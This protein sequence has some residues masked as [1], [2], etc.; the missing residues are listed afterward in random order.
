MSTLGL[1]RS[2]NGNDWIAVNLTVGDQVL[3]SPT[4]NFATWNK[5]DTASDLVTLS[6]GNL[7]AV[8][9]STNWAQT[10]ANIKPT[11]G[12]W[13][14]ECLQPANTF[15]GI[16][17]QTTW[18]TNNTGDNKYIGKYNN[19]FGFRF[20]DYGSGSG[21][22]EGYSTGSSF[23]SLGTAQPASGD[24]LQ[25]ALDFDNNKIWWGKN[26]T[27]YNS[28]NP[29]TGANGI[30]I[31]ATEHYHIGISTQSSTASV[32]NFGQDSSFAGNK[33]AQGNQ[34]SN[35]IGDFY[36]TPPTGFLALCTKN[37]PDVAVVPSEHFNTVLYTGTG[38]TYP[39]TT[40][41]VTG[42]G[43]QPDW[44]WIKIRSQAYQHF[45]YDAVRGATKV[46]YSDSTAA[47][48]TGNQMTSFNSDGFTVANISTGVATNAS[49]E[50]FVAWNWK[51]N[52]S[53][54]SNTNGSVTSTVSANVDAGF[55]IVSYTGTGSNATVGHGLSK[56]PEMM[57]VKD[58]DQDMHWFVYHTGLTNADYSVKMDNTQ[59]QA[60]DSTKWNGT[61]PTSS[62]FS[63][64]TEVGVSESGNKYIAY[65]FH[66]VEGYSKVGDYVGND[67][68]NGTFVY[69]G[70]QPAYVHIN[71]PNTDGEGFVYMNNKSDPTNV[72]GTY[73]TTYGTTQE[74]GT[75]GT[76]F[77][78]SIDFVSNGFKLRGNSTE[79]NDGE[80]IIFYAVAETPLKYANAR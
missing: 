31:S 3:D 8:E 73:L 2:G 20:N 12:K 1:D 21:N 71:N 60:N 33:T 79:I 43:F 69:C 41:S 75:A 6:E 19:D 38:G 70:F 78:R 27:W 68:A 28:G 37:L 30:S 39:S 16:V 52:G 74:Q 63:I 66:S 51:A 34:D 14:L 62:V 5:L 49:G 24:I 18:G 42:V 35:D 25:M 45:I 7:S 47:E 65:C 4:N 26:N 9:N 77:S 59:V 23:T 61:D 29:A 56:A 15:F 72:T 64:G 57:I 46:I 54:S 22:N 67:N 13:Y 17:S 11:T 76:T 10:F 40:Q 48:A 50:S 80:V 36:Y 53:G 32:V 44:T 55:S 58:R